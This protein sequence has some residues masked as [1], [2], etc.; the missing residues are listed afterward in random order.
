MRGICFKEPLFHKVVAGEK[1]QTRRI[2]FPNTDYTF[3]S[4][5]TFE[6]METDPDAVLRADNEGN[7]KCY[8]DGTEKLFKLKGTY[9]L[10]EGDQ[11]WFDCSYVRPKYQPNEILFLKEPY[12]PL[13]GLFPVFKYEEIVPEFEGNPW[14]NK[15][16]MP[17]KY[18]RYF[19]QITDVTAEHAHDI[20]EADAIAEGCKNRA[21]FEGLWMQINGI[22]SWKL[23]P[24]V[25]KYT[26][27]NIYEL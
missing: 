25:W 15:L 6:G 2:T 10:F 13:E 8:A 9:G 14:K 4:Q 1:T 3:W 19:I 21:E 27:K 11:F 23:N 20:T 12:I 5:P 18:A 22:S 17:E 26:F 7:A 16:F 24:W